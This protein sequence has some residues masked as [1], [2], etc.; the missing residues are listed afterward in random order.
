MGT[1]QPFI[2]TNYNYILYELYICNVLDDISL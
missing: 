1:D 2:L